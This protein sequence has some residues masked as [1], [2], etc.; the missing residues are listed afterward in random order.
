MTGAMRLFALIWRHGIREIN[1]R[2]LRHANACALQEFQPFGTTVERMVVDL[3]D[4][5]LLNQ[6]GTVN[7]GTVRNKDSS[8]FTGVPVFGELSNGV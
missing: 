3:G 8:A 2:Q 5:T 4:P 6:K 1:V 7:A